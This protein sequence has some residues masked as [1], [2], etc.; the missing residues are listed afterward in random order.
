[1]S[2]VNSY[3]YEQIHDQRLKEA[4]NV[5]AIVKVMSFD[6]SRMTVSVQPLSKRLKNGKYE[7]P[8]PIL[9]VPVAVTRTGGFIFRPWVKAGDVGVVV[10]LDHDMDSAVTGGKETKPMTERSHSTSD[11]IFIG[12]IVSSGFAADEFPDDACVL[13]KDDGLVYIAVTEE[14]VSIKNKET[15]AEFTEDSAVLAKADGQI[16]LS[17]TDESVSIKNN[18]TTAEFKADSVEITATTVNITGDVTVNGALTSG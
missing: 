14:S 17:I 15:T 16:S 10:Y 18:D 12:G 8:P 5:A 2:S 11:A 1:M 3:N 9:Q 13:A 6:K 4:I 7:T